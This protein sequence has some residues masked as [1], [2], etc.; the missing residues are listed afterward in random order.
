MSTV[1]T[2][3]THDHCRLIN[4]RPSDYW[5]VISVQ[6]RITILLGAGASLDICPE[7]STIR[8]TEFL[9]SDQT[10]DLPYQMDED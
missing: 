4:M 9:F 10:I 8:I 7:L 6:K 3:S 2:Y 5:H 1:S